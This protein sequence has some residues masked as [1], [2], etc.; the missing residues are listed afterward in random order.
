MS[1]LSQSAQVFLDDYRSRRNEVIGAA[2]LAQDIVSRI[3]KETGAFVHV[4]SAI[5][6][7]HF[8]APAEGFGISVILGL[9]GAFWGVQIATKIGPFWGFHRLNP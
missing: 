6:D 8:L 3:V 2:E 7:F 9:N 1:G 4:V 5:N